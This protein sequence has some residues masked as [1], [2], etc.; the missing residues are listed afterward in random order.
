VLTSQLL[1]QTSRI[2]QADPIAQ[3]NYGKKDATS[4]AK[5]KEIFSA[6]PISIPER[7]ETYEKESYERITSLINTVDEEKS[8][9][10]KEVF[11]SFLHKV[12]KRSK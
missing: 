1:W 8:G 3:D 11:L 10:K 5:V 7:F 4:E 9:L 12:Y 6:S 2:R